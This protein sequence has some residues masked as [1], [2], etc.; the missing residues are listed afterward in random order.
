MPGRHADQQAADPNTWRTAP[1]RYPERGRRRAAPRASRRATH[2]TSSSQASRGPRGRPDHR[3]DRR[4]LLRPAATRASRVRTRLEPPVV[5]LAHISDPHVGSPFFVPNLM[6]RVIAEINE[7]QPDVVVCSGD[8][9][10]EGY[11]QEYKNWVAY[12]ERIQAPDH[13]RSGQP[14]L[15]QRRLP[16]LRGS[17]RPSHVVSR[18]RRRSHRG[19]RLQRARPQRGQGR[20]RP[21]RLDPPPVRGARGAEG[22]RAAPP[23]AADPRHRARAQHGDGCRRPARGAHQRRRAGRAFRATS[24]CRTSGGWR[25]CTSPTPARCR[26]CGSAGTPSRATTCWS[27]TATRS[28]IHRRFPFGDSHVMTHFSLAGDQLHREHEAPIQ[29]RTVPVGE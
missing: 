2:E 7:M 1:R 5:T 18:R 9:T 10:A 3:I 22:V 13:H 8:L 25:T 23:P 27:S 21:L 12:A 4:G 29:Q 20:P 15:P 11:R 28:S 26:P 16:A 17:D 6:N 14:R 19:G 24:T